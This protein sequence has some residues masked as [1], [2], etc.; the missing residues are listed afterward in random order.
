M[1]VKK[2]ASTAACIVCLIASLIGVLPFFLPVPVGT[3]DFYI[4]MIIEMVVFAYSWN[5]SNK[6]IAI[7]IARVISGIVC[8]GVVAVLLGQIARIVTGS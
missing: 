5:R 6:N 2:Q 7:G 1:K 4:I 8:V 3:S